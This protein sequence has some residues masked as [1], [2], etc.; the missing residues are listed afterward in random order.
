MVTVVLTEGKVEP[1]EL[2]QGTTV[3]ASMMM[4]VAEADSTV[5]CGVDASQFRFQEKAI[6]PWDRINLQ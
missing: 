5:A 4:V 1:A 2:V 3:V 6:V